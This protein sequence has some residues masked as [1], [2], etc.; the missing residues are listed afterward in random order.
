MLA[1][2]FSNGWIRCVK[3]KKENNAFKITDLKSQKIPD[4]I[5]NHSLFSNE[6]KNFFL[7]TFN[8]LFS[9]IKYNENENISIC[10]DSNWIETKI[11]PLDIQ[12]NNEVK[13][14]YL[15]WYLNQR[16]GDLIKNSRVFFKNLNFID[17]K[18]SLVL[19]SIIPNTILDLLKI[20]TSKNFLRPI[21]LEPS[22]ISIERIISNNTTIVFENS[23]LTKIQLY[24][25][26]SIVGEGQC[27]IK[28]NSIELD[29]FSGNVDKVKFIIKTINENIS[30]KK[31]DVLCSNDFSKESSQFFN[32]RKNFLSKI[33]PFISNK[34]K[35]EFELNNKK[36]DLSV[37]SELFGLMFR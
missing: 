25:K 13:K 14:K 16:H 26:G 11:L 3:S 2:S 20:S 19:C 33:N 12:L 21:F 10:M 8:N 7:T 37:F 9:S 29:F 35:I 1:V 32:L 27:K 18:K 36:E 24:D 4:E 22:I 17:E 15:Y 5:N 31:I 34:S 28:S 23:K 30:D 6:Y